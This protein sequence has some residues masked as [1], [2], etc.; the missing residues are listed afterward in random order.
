MVRASVRKLR[1]ALSSRMLAPPVQSLPCAVAWG[2]FLYPR[3]PRSPMSSREM[4]SA[5]NDNTPR[6]QASRFAVTIFTQASRDSRTIGDIEACH[7]PTRREVIAQHSTRLNRL[8]DAT[9]AICL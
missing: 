3:K 4:W 8:C 9:A 1:G 5:R 7:L 2:S 6:I